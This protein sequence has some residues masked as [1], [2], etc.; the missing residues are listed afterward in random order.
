MTLSNGDDGQLIIS[1]RG[2]SLG[3]KRRERYGLLM[4]LISTVLSVSSWKECM[5]TTPLSRSRAAGAMR[6]VWHGA[7]PR[8]RSKTAKRFLRLKRLFETAKEPAPQRPGSG[9]PRSD[10]PI[11]VFVNI[12]FFEGLS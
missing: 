7:H 8:T 1:E 10:G 6:S 9:R 4:T 12:R 2:L 3:E 11:K 5:S